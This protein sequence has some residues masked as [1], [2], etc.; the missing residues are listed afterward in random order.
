MKR[1]AAKLLFQFRVVTD[2]KCGKRRL[3]EERIISLKATSALKA[4]N[5]AKRKGRLGQYQYTNCDGRSVY[6]EF[7]GV[8]DL[9]CLGL[10]CT[11]DEVW[12]DIVK[13]LLPLE[14]KDKFIPP[15]SE[16]NAIRHCQ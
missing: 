12:Y 13:R 10:E 11:E 2:G 5:F 16:L 9:L 3:C 8:M 15:E 1:Y 6:F 7:I 4:L 14:R